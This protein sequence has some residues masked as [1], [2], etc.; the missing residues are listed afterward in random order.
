MMTIKQIA[1]ICGISK[2]SVNRVIKELGIIPTMS[3]NKNMLSDQDADRIVLFLR[4]FGLNSETIKPEPAQTETKS[5]QTET[6]HDISVDNRNSI[7]EKNSDQLV[8]FLMEQIKEKDKQIEK[9]QD[10][11]K[12]LMQAHA[13]ALKQLEDKSQIEPK[14]KDIIQPEV[15]LQK[16]KHFLSWLFK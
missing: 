3:G 1:D 4:G 14:A 11:N 15:E 8:D 6:E 16:K 5:E 2:T 9:L 13:F 10:E 12:I 7:S